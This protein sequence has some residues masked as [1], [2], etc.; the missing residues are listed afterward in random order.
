MKNFIYIMLFLGIVLPGKSQTR[1]E[2]NIPVKA[3]QRV[4]MNF[5][6]PDLITINTWDKNEIGIIAS[7]N[8]NQ[9]EN[10]DAFEIEHNAGEVLR[11]NSQ[12]K[13]YQDLPE[14]ISLKYKGQEYFFNTSDWNSPEIQRF[15]QDKGADANYDYMR[16]GVIMDITLEIMVPKGIELEVDAK[17][18]LVE[19][20]GFTRDMEIQSKFGG[21]D[22][23]VEP[24]L[25]ATMNVSTKFG[26]VYSNLDMRLISRGDHQ[27]GRWME[28]EGKASSGTNR[29]SLRSEFGNVYLRKR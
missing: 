11:I 5:K 9:G 14:R 20:I 13:N 22:V 6:F 24:S 16:R 29:Q 2:K 4:E 19:V 3:G 12:I 28:L 21:I 10:D 7:V 1:F 26:E 8:I 17:H 18:G 23:S 27:I 15:K 25:S